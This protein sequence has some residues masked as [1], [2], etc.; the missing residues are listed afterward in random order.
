MI[1]YEYMFIHSFVNKNRQDRVLFELSNTKKRADCIRS[2]S[3]FHKQQL[4]SD[5]LIM[6]THKCSPKDVRDKITALGY[7]FSNQVYILHFNPDFDRIILSF[8]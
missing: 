8:Q 5:K 1:D 2:F 4:K 3:E 6:L 7:S